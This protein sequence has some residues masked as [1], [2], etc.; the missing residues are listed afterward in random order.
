MNKGHEGQARA[1]ASCAKRAGGLWCYC[2]RGPPGAGACSQLPRS[3]IWSE[4][5]GKA[6][7]AACC[8]QGKEKRLRGHDLS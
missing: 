1:W 5:L 7:Q 8:R 3:I 4:V 6:G 2:F